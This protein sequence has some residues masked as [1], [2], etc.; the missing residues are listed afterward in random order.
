MKFTIARNARTSLYELHKDGCAHTIARHMEVCG[1]V[2]GTDGDTVAAYEAD[3][4][5]GCAY[6][7]GPCVKRGNHLVHFADEAN[8]W[9]LTS[10]SRAEWG[11]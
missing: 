3:H 5:D 7:T 8:N 1:N 2:E 10:I 4:N 11:A 6:T 9:T